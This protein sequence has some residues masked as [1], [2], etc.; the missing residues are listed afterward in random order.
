MIFQC[1]IIVSLGLCVSMQLALPTGFT[2]GVAIVDSVAFAIT[3]ELDNPNSA[4]RFDGVFEDKELDAEYGLFGVLRNTGTND[5]TAAWRPWSTKSSPEPPLF[6]YE[7]PLFFYELIDSSGKRV[8]ARIQLSSKM[9]K[10]QRFSRSRFRSLS[11]RPKEFEFLP[12]GMIT[13]LFQVTRPGTYTLAVQLRYW[14][15]TNNYATPFL[16]PPVRLPVI[17]RETALPTAPA[18]APGKE[19]RPGSK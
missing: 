19:N 10:K 9:P 14:T 11:P 7:P 8:S 1:C 5:L 12:F 6:V 13:N 15:V 2:N 16:S 3:D 18:P 4:V 17:V